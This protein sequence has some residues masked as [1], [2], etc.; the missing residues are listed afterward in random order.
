MPE[1]LR[2]VGPAIPGHEA[3][4]SPPALEFVAAL[5]R[6]FTGRRDALL[7]ER[8]RRQAR[9]DAGERLEFPAETQSL[10]EASW[11]VAAAPRD[12]LDRRVEVTGPPRRG[13]IVDGL[14][15]GARVFVADLE[16]ATAPTWDDVV[17]A[18]R[19]LAETVSTIE[20]TALPGGGRPRPGRR[21][22]ALML[23]PRA[24]HR[25]E[26][27]VLLGERPA[28]AF[29]FD[30][31]LYLFHNARALLERGTGPYFCL[32]QLESRL[33]ARLWND[34]FLSAQA[35]LGIA[36]GTIKA[37]VRIETLP[38]SFEMDEMLHA[39]REHS[40]GLC[41]EHRN[42]VL[43]AIQTLRTDSAWRV[44]EQAHVA[45]ERRFPHAHVK[46]AVRTCH[47]RG[48]HCLADGTAWRPASDPGRNRLVLDA[49]RVETLRDVHDGL[50]GISVAHPGLVSAAL[51][52]FET[53]VEG[54][55][56]LQI[57]REDVRVG[58][59]DLLRAP[60]GCRGEA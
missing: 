59:A 25:P 3:V 35:K 23:R 40:V 33:E 45:G 31:G 30:F 18:Q 24:L 47:R 32:P 55:H 11:R 4:L 34:V 29:L 15:S 27:H 48:A 51:E 49:L 20:E 19:H 22:P 42:Y 41:F 9:L 2:V 21:A 17:G 16:V 58:S 57:K 38:A 7:E 13:S 54:P 50:D 26:A 8:R 43:S 60:L 36:A 6:E 39:L 53:H 52:V 28:P 12:L 14:R 10:R 44:R 37:C 1:A 46:L 56:Q 5:A